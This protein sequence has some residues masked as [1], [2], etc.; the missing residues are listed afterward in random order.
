LRKRER[1]KGEEKKVVV[2]GGFY[3]FKAV[4]KEKERNVPTLQLD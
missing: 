3:G 4:G 1:E 2:V